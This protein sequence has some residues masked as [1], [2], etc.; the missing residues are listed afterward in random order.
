[1]LSRPKGKNLALAG[2]SLAVA[3]FVFLSGNSGA[4]SVASPVQSS[5]T[6][7]NVP[8]AAPEDIA[9]DAAGN[10]YIS[11][12]DGNRIDRVD[13]N[14]MFT[15]VAGTGIAGF[16]GDGGPATD[17]ELNAPAGL[18]VD[19]TG[20]LLVADHHNH[21]IRRIGTDGII[22]TI[23][24]TCTKHGTQGDGG[25]ATH[26][27]LN[28]PIGITEDAS[29]NLFIADEQN[30]LVRRV[31]T[32]GVIT[33]VAGG[34]DI[35]VAKAPNGTMATRLRLKHPSYVVVD[36]SGNLYFSD[37]CAN[38]VLKVD[39][40]GRATRIAGQPSECFAGAFSGDHG[41]AIAAELNFPTGLA[42][43]ARGRL[44]ISD[45]VNNRIR[46]I[47]RN[48]RIST[49]AGTGEAAYAGDGGPA[50]RAALTLSAGL[51]FDGEGN[52][53]IADQGNNVVRILDRSGEI[54]LFAGTP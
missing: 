21:C 39:G 22:S 38:V 32:N 9:F 36:T 1:M 52:L 16:S 2:A 15:V 31:G 12:F 51:A 27:R 24:G 11:E 50:V 3:S 54:T 44:F 17:A 28:D 53:F 26:A 42:F 13:P 49:V 46:M 14:G 41:P 45:T 43:D 40:S 5:V 19:A 29:G 34:G 10:T 7:T 18:F 23:A 37:F 25:P 30:A 48:G 4:G 35:P 47:D 20:A 33:T 6:A 8:I